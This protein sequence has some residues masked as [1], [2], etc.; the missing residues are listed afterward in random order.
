[1]FTE[2]EEFRRS[3]ARQAQFSL[4]F[5]FCVLQRP[6]KPENAV[7]LTAERWEEGEAEAAGGTSTATFSLGGV[8]GNFFCLKKYKQ[9][10]GRH[11][12]WHTWPGRRIW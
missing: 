9:D 10:G 8:Y 7:N 11:K 5:F 12:Y 6:R 3:R 4:L 2:S 1:M